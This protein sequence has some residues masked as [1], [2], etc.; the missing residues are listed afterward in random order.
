MARARE[1]GA[2]SASFIT[3]DMGDHSRWQDTCLSA[4]SV[5]PV[6]SL[7]RLYAGA[8]LQSAPGVDTS[9]PGRAHICTGNK[10][11]V[12]IRAGTRPTSVAGINSGG[13]HFTLSAR[14]A[15]QPAGSPLRCAAS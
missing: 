8:V 2:A 9:A 3:A 4:S 10:S 15:G 14:T 1:L 5:A 7:P 11:L 6:G 12:R 13:P